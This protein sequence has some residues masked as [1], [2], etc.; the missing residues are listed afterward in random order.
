MELRNGIRFLVTRPPGLKSRIG[1]K[2]T[3]ISAVNP[4]IVHCKGQIVLAIV[5][6]R[7]KRC[8]NLLKA[9]CSAW[10]CAARRGVKTH[11]RADLDT[12]LQKWRVC[13]VLQGAERG[14]IPLLLFPSLGD[15]SDAQG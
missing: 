14:A 3:A 5:Q 15:A 7:C 12:G 9:F 1:S 8:L 2:L 13:G 6:A 4:L 11:I 10:G